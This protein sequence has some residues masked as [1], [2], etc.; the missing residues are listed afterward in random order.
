MQKVK[1]T[2]LELHPDIQSRAQLDMIII[3]EYANLMREGI[4]FPPIDVISENGTRFVW[5]G[6]H[7]V[8]A[9]KSASV[10]QLWAK[11]EPGTFQQAQ[12]KASGANTS[13]GLRRI[14]FTRLPPD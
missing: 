11:I 10:E 3:Q 6:F 2:D 7:R 5:D 13:H 8:H 4:D 12:W 14:P 9:A 1:I